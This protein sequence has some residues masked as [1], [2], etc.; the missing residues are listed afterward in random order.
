M[1]KTFRVS[2][3]K[4]DSGFTDTFAECKTLRKALAQFDKAVEEYKGVDETHGYQITLEFE[5]YQGNGHIILLE[6][7]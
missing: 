5:D 4:V 7:V 3:G 1:K 6:T 2:Y